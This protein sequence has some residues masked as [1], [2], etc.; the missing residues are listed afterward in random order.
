MRQISVE[1]KDQFFQLMREEFEQHL[2]EKTVQQVDQFTRL[3]LEMAP[4]EELN[5]RRLSDLY[6]AVIA[7]WHFVQEHDGEQ[8][9]VV[10]FNPDL[11]E[12]GWQST[13]TVVG[14]LYE[15]VPFIVD[16]IRMALQRH[17]L[18]IHTMQHSVLYIRRDQQG[19]LQELL[20]RDQER[21]RELGESMMY[22]E[23]NRHNDR[24]DREQI[25]TELTTVLTEVRT[26]ISDYEAMKQH[27]IDLTEELKQPAPNLSEVAVS[28]AQEFLHWLVADHFTFLGYDEYDFIKEGDEIELRQVK[29]SQLGILKS[30]QERPGTLRLSD[31][32]SRTAKMIM[33]PELFVFA[34]STKRSRVHRPAY[35]DY[36]SVKKF[37][38]AGEVT[39]ERRFLGLYTA[40]VYQQRPH[41]IPLLRTKV[42][43]VQE[44]SGLDPMDYAGKE[45]EQ[46]LTVY[47]RDELFQ[48]SS[49]ELLQTAFSILYIQERRKIRLF[50]RED[51]YGQFISVLVFVPRDQY[52]TSLRERITAILVD[53]TEAEDVE[54]TTYFS[55]SVLARTQFNLRVP[56]R[57]QRNIKLEEL[58]KKVIAAAQSWQDG[59]MEGLNE[60]HGEEQANTLIH[61][62]ANAFS[63]SY[64]ETFSPR[65][66]VFDIDHIHSLSSEK[67]LAL[68]FYRAIEENDTILHFKL[69]HE[70]TTVP[71]SD[72]LPLFENLG[73][74]VMGEHPFET[75]DRNG[76]V[77]WIHDFSLQSYDNSVIEISRIR[78]VFESLFMKVWFKEAENDAFNRLVLTAQM[79]WRQIAMFR[80]YARYMRQIRSSYSQNFI[81][82]TLVNHVQI[83]ELIFQL[84][85]A[86]LNPDKIQ[87]EVQ[88]AA[89]QQK[90][91]IDIN[92]ALDGVENLSEDRVLNRYVELIKATLRTNYYQLSA[93]GE[94]KP[95]MSFKVRP[96]DIPDMPLPLPMFE[97]FVY[98]P[99]V[100]GVHLRG[101]KV[102]RGGLRWSDRFEDYRTEVLGL[103]KAQQVKN[104]VIVPVGAKGGFVAKQLPEQGREAILTEGIACYRHFISGLLDIT[105]NYIGGEVVPPAQVVR[106]DEN[107]YYLVV[108][109][110]K[111]TATFSDIANTLSAEYNFWL[112]DAFASGGSQGYDHKKMGI[113]ARGAW[114]AVER[115][116]REMGINTNTDEFTVVGVG[117]MSGDVFG[118]GMLLSPHIRLLAAFNHLHIFIDPEPNAASSFAE[119][120]RLFNLP[121]SG[122]NDYNGELISEGGGIFSRN[123]KSIP[124]SDSMKKRFDIRQDR[125][126]PNM[127]IA[128]LLQSQA[129]LLWFGGIG[130]YVKSNNE[131]H[132]DVGDKA[133]DG[134]RVD[135]RDLQVK[136]VGE[137][138]N[139]GMTHLGRIEFALNGGRLNTDFIDNAGGVDCSDHEVNIKILLNDVVANGDMTFK[140]RNKL[141][142]DMTD[143]VAELV[144]T[145]TYRQTQA[146]SVAEREAPARVEEYQRLIDYLESIGKLNRALE[147]IPDNEAITE[148]KSRN[149][150]LTRPELSTLI[151]Y[152]KGWLKESL[153]DSD[154]ADKIFSEELY[155]EFP[156]LLIEKFDPQLQQHQLR[157][158]IIA[159][160]VAN[161][162]VNHL[163]ITFV[164]RMRQSTGASIGAIAQ[165]YVLARNVFRLPELWQQIEA[166]DYQITADVQIEMMSELIRLVRRSARWFLRNRR[167]EQM[168]MDNMQRFG[169][170]IQTIAH[171]FED[172]LSGEQLLM[173]QERYRSLT[174]AKV[175]ETLAKIIA[176]A[177]FLYSALGIIEAQEKSSAELDYVARLFFRLG[178]NLDLQWFSHQI[179]IARPAGHWQTLARESFREDL[180][181]QQRSLT[182]AVLMLSDAPEDI[183]E[184][185]TAWAEGHADMLKR[186]RT[187]LTELKAMKTLE[188]PMYSVALRELMD[189][190]QSTSHGRNPC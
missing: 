51:V 174:E 133:N 131:S 79:D 85:E 175:P 146:L 115:H 177:P 41:E 6:G 143:A 173:W 8:T 170:K 152:V 99:R 67:P 78:H 132:N 89:A 181:G 16:S 108:A 2:D 36:I 160:Q 144:L 81:A 30:H 126:P 64:R 35:P 129:D 148:R 65:R 55:E 183:D 156:G 43:Y 163:G 147:F 7:C 26:A 11:E 59:L 107:D 53:A 66:A 10:V 47:P 142:V 45:V 127:L 69:F 24:A 151:S 44:Q 95:Y 18:T 189:L 25:C 134:L 13:H 75:I 28:E 62:Y 157:Q 56:A 105:D 176:G 4:L 120:Q 141:L 87:S 21:P 113:T 52:S 23:I 39:G 188:F 167:A 70:N 72:V 37:N 185:I 161:H 54:F 155:R 38:A 96:T 164:D 48:I 5:G 159:T 117:D 122:W 86:R 84:F 116:F 98:S 103:V 128:K 14:I 136:V 40:R 154:L 135:A 162:M 17:E 138:G 165:A 32:S 9:K 123:T 111:G 61:C 73:L 60:A 80:S 118:N 34:K 42:A 166:L 150:G 153:I 77:V 179:A 15:N 93:S 91:E 172:L 112:G 101:G 20:G 88:S 97:I 50:M 182:E 58:E 110:D 31:L 137:G 139:L 33:Q 145:N 168:V 104:S 94:P 106:H 149:L 102:A 140:Q 178:E 19:Q 76:K 125:L 57:E 83:A 74:R 71:L 29:G 1:N 186:W 68:S 119:R 46:I 180:E 90:L 190:A 109:A 171:H 184:R 169:E 3:Y 63:A 27:A 130:T 187:M 114:V 12:H 158:E 49:E 22:V 82:S 92:Q 124:I 121:R 100:E